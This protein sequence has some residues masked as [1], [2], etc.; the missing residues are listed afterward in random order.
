MRRAGCCRA[1]N[2]CGCRREGRGP[3]SDGEPSQRNTCPTPFA[4]PSRCQDAASPGRVLDPP[5]VC[6]AP[7]DACAAGPAASV[8]WSTARA[9]RR[10][11][12][13]EPGRTGRCVIVSQH[14]RGCCCNSGTRQ[15]ERWAHREVRASCRVRHCS[16]PSRICLRAQKQSL[17]FDA[18]ACTL[19]A[20]QAGLT[21]WR[22]DSHGRRLYSGLDE[23]KAEQ[24]EEEHVHG[25]YNTISSHFSHTR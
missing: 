19:F 18:M 1:L 8:G 17:P 6:R 2:M 4:R 13:T 3:E 22:S 25:V 7:A 5:S 12:V 15:G 10:Y 21:A 20:L 9:R 24:F 14:E 23:E 11:S 16:L